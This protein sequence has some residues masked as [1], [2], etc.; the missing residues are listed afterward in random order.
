M[1]QPDT[2]DFE[3]LG[4]SRGSATGP[5]DDATQKAGGAQE[6]DHGAVL[7]RPG[8]EP[9]LGQ[10]G[11]VGVVDDL[12]LQPGRRAEQPAMGITDLS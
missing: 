9:H 3:I 4:K 10:A 8:A 6:H 12:A 7:P 2:P 11:C 5:S 1:H